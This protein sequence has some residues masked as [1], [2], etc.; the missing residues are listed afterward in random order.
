MANFHCVRKKNEVKGVV[1]YGELKD[2]EEYYNFYK[3]EITLLKVIG[4][5][6]KPITT[7]VDPKLTSLYY[8]R[9]VPG[10]YFL[11][12]YKDKDQAYSNY[13]YCCFNNLE[14]PFYPKEDFEIREVGT[15]TRDNG[16][17]NLSL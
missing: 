2:I 3:P 14:E 5:K 6:G 1:I 7:S 10:V 4:D 13:R 17:L 16:K 11:S 12:P 15:I 9:G 8:H